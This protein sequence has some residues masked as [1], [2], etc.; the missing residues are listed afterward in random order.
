MVT[1]SEIERERYEARLKG[2]RDRSCSLFG[3][4]QEGRKEG[5]II[6]AL[7]GKI[8]V[9][10]TYLKQPVTPDTALEQL[11]VQELTQMKNELER[12]LFPPAVE[13]DEPLLVQAAHS[14]TSTHLP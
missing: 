10:Q 2:M 12:Q 14:S 8:F 5:L 11:S 7:M 9:Y 3:A 6:G 1:Q 4:S 13:A